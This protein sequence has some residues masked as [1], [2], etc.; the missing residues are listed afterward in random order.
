MSSA[1]HLEGTSV[2]TAPPAS[3]MRALRQIDPKARLIHL[4]GRKWWL[5]VQDPQPEAMELAGDIRENH[6][7]KLPQQIKNEL[8][9]ALRL[10]MLNECAEG[11]RPIAV[12]ECDVPGEDVIEDFRIRDHNWRH[13]ADATV[14]ERLREASFEE[15]FEQR[16]QA[17]REMVQA[18][19][20]S[21]HKYVLRRAKGFWQRVAAPFS[22]K[23]D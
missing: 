13:R 5:G 11:F 7:S 2:R 18:T 20:P 10:E 1:L 19:F 16:K 14:E 8:S 9:S 12:Y 4:G 3:T 22:S 21:I 17:M 6:L 23:G 15:Q